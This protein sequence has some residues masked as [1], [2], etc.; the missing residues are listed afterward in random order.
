MTQRTENKAAQINHLKNKLD[1][2][3]TSQLGQ[4]MTIKVH[5]QKS[6]SLN[7]NL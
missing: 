7:Y 6:Q 3:R 1:Y 4:H 2:Q 5:T